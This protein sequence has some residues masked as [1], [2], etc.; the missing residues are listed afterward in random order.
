[1]NKLFFK[2][3][4]PFTFLIVSPHYLSAQ[5][6]AVNFTVNDCDGVNHDLFATL[7]AGK[8]VV[9]VWVMPC[10]GCIPDAVDA[11]NAVESFSLS[12]PGKVLYYLV[13][14][15]ANSSCSFVRGWGNTNGIINATVFSDSAISMSDYGID[16]MPKVIV[17][18]GPDHSVFYNENNAD[19]TQTGVENA[20]NA[21]LD[22]AGTIEEE[23]TSILKVYPNPVKDL[24]T[25]RLMNDVEDNQ[26]FYLYDSSGKEIKSFSYINVGDGKNEIQ[27]NLT[28]LRSGS[29]YLSFE[30]S[31]TIEHVK[32]VVVH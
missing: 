4:F 29:Y 22:V 30:H 19:I 31:Q 17:L 7:D 8:V 23:K 9:I 11:Y 16:G 26:T 2:L 10:A 3:V 1:M 27:F 14:D 18:G 15:Y 5:T 13:D 12:Q 25:I 20:I 21:A 6:T 32:I 24:L 28:E